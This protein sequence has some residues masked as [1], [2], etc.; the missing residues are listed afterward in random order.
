MNAIGFMCLAITTILLWKRLRGGGRS[1][2]LY[3]CPSW[4]QNA[5]FLLYQKV[6]MCP[7]PVEYKCLQQSWDILHRPKY[8]E[9]QWGEQ[10]AAA[11]ARIREGTSYDDEESRQASRRFLYIDGAPG[12]G[13]TAVLLEAAVQASQSMEVL[14]AFPT[15]M[16]VH[17][18]KSMLPDRPGIENIRVEIAQF[19]IGLGG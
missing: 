15:G 13:K 7:D 3:P 14:V 19:T 5:T 6:R 12:S 9:K 16:Q 1:S 10:Q 11:L 8:Q 2:Y 18:F 17:S 4:K